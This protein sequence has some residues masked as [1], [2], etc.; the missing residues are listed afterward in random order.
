MN[1]A[2]GP[3]GMEG[4]EME[5][6]FKSLLGAG[7]WTWYE[8]SGYSIRTWR[9]GTKGLLSY[10]T[11]EYLVVR[12]GLRKWEVRRDGEVWRFGSQWELL[13]WFGDRL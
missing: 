6:E 2:D 11:E 8:A 1:G 12:H 5:N 7:A 13:A 4:T 3:P 10:G 9:G